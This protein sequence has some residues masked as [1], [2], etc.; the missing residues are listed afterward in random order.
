MNWVEWLV[1]ENGVVDFVFVFTTEW[2]LLEEHLVDE[3]TEGPPVHC[4][5]VLLV[6]QNLLLC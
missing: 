4:T 3:N 1:G 5:T 2:G 6:K